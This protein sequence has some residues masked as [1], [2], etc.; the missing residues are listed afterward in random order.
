MTDNQ[1][2]AP[3]QAVERA[4]QVLGLFVGGHTDLDLSE[5]A[6]R[7]GFS[8]T[9]AHRYL[10]SLRATGL[11]RYEPETGLYG[12]GARVIELGTS[13]LD[14]LPIVGIAEPHLN[15]LVNRVD[16]TAVMTVWDGQ[17]PVVVFANDNTSAIVRISVRVGSRLPLFRSAQG[18]IYLALSPSIRRQF[19]QSPELNALRADLERVRQSGVS[20]RS[21]V[22]QGI[23]AVGAPVFRANDV[24]ATI[25]LVGTEGTMPGETDN[26]MVQELVLSA[27]EL[28]RDLSERL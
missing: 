8:K 15:Q 9:T 23:R 14:S 11:L 6:R 3:I 17:A 16:R 21:D 7:L 4:A 10:L 20:I 12:L 27:Q 25:A 26:S 5:I 22:S 13:A 24:A 18:H 2:N 19:E 28:S 1:A